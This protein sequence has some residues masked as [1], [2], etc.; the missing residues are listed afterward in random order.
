V[1]VSASEDE[2]QQEPEAANEPEEF[3]NRAAR[4]A[5]GKKHWHVDARAG[6]DSQP[7]GRGTAVPGRR[8]YGN[9]RTGG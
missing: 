2:Q 6:A 9:R 7:H 1:R 5:K 8:A 3:L 4:R